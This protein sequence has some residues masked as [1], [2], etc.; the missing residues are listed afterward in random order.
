M[1]ASSHPHIHIV[2]VTSHLVHVHLVIVHL[3][4][5]L[6]VHLVHVPYMYTSS[7]LSYAL[8]QVYLVPVLPHTSTSHTHTSA[9]GGAIFLHP[10]RRRRPRRPRRKRPRPGR[11]LRYCC[12]CCSHHCRCNGIGG[13]MY[14]GSGPSDG[15]RM[16]RRRVVV[17]DIDVVDAQGQHPSIGSCPRRS[18]GAEGCR[19]RRLRERTSVA[20]F[21]D[22]RSWQRLHCRFCRPRRRRCREGRLLPAENPRTS[23]SPRW[24]VYCRH[25]SRRRRLLSPPLCQ[26]SPSPPRR[27]VCHRV[28]RRSMTTKVSTSPWPSRRRRPSQTAAA[29]PLAPPPRFRRRPRRPRSR[30]LTPSSS[31]WARR[32]PLAVDSP[33]PHFRRSLHPRS[34]SCP[35]SWAFS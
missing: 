13:R 5:V 1:C 3:V 25:P 21:S 19:V 2:L 12:R 14:R 23:Y 30:Y 9:L 10:R 32:C 26:S 22:G 27:H 29:V 34:W 24:P 6:L 33:P 15:R 8:V 17:S 28:R 35:A 16:R 11:R 20:V 4:L 7:S 18:D 31:R